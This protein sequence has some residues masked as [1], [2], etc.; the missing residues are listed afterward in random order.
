[1]AEVSLFRKWRSRTFS[2]LVGQES[3]VRTLRNVLAGGSP[4]RAYLFC[5]PRGTGKTSSARIF[6]KALCCEHRNGLEPC[7]K[8]VTCREIALGSCLDVFE[9][10]AA[11]HTQ[12]EKIRDFIVD[13]VHFAPARAPFKVYI[14]DE[15]HK[16]SAASFNALLKTLEEPPPHVVFILATTHP[17]EVLPTILSRCQR[18]DFRPLSVA[19]IRA[20]LTE[21][22]LAE[23]TELHPDAAGLLARAAD[24]SLRDALVLLEQ[25]LCFCGPTIEPTELEGLLGL[26][27]HVTLESLVEC[28]LAQDTLG[29]L[30][31]L[32]E[33]VQAGHDLSRFANTALEHLRSLM[34]VRAGAHDSS[35]EA[36]PELARESLAR[37]AERVSLGQLMAWLKAMLELTQAIRDGGPPRLLWEM[38]AVQLTAPAAAAAPPAGLEALMSRVERLERRLSGSPEGPGPLKLEQAAERPIPSPRPEQAAPPARPGR[39]FTPPPRGAETSGERPAVREAPPPREPERSAERPAIREAPPPREPERPVKEAPA[40]ERWKAPPPREPERVAERAAAPAERGARPTPAANT[41]TGKEFWRELM[42]QVKG[43]KTRP[44]LFHVLKE[45]RLERLEGDT[46]EL[47]LPEKFRTFHFEEIKAGRAELESVSAQILARK[48]AVVCNLRSDDDVLSDDDAHAA[49]ERKAS[50]FFAGTI[51]VEQ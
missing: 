22:A 7:D 24:G 9:I 17:H 38:T 11:S 20:R 1:M 26:V 43:N 23:G 35:L 12:V 51:I 46:V 25:A 50:S 15:V 33:Q 14:I 2:D 36:L 42:N 34:L 48:V 47:S 18:Y 5:G 30:T 44:R 49:M 37:Q 31:L 10:D 21:V 13:K 29:V 40:E 6:A 27:P 41:T 28:V 32:H 39:E 4:A 8:C 3:V 19:E 45:A 16:L